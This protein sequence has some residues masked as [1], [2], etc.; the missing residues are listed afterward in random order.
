MYVCSLQLKMTIHQ[1]REAQLALLLA[2][3]VT[4]PTEYSDLADVFLEKSA[5]VLPE[6]IGTN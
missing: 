6:W 1:A 4:V 3:K 5:N 2:E